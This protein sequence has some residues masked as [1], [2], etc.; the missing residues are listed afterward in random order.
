[1]LVNHRNR[2]DRAICALRAEQAQI[3]LSSFA[4]GFNHRELALC[5]SAQNIGI[6]AF[7]LIRF[8]VSDEFGKRRG[9]FRFAFEYG[10]HKNSLVFF[11]QLLNILAR[12][13][14]RHVAVNFLD[15]CL[16]AAPRVVVVL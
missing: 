6:D 4:T 7:L 2:H 10:K 12:V 9:S 3:L 16:V 8:C 5:G 11:N 14:F 15:V 1:M 13:L